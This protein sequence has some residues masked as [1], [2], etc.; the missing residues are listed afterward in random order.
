MMDENQR[1]DTGQSI[2]NRACPQHAVS[3]PEQ[4]ENQNQRKQ[5]KHL[6][7]ERYDCPGASLSNGRKKRSAQN[8]S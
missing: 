2:C 8:N 7:A 6:A 4:R 3:F 1:Q 5:E